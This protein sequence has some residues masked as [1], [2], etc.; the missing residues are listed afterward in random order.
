MRIRTNKKHIWIVPFLGLLLSACGGGGDSGGGGTTPTPTPTPTNQAPTISGSP[1]TS[2]TI[3]SSYTFTPQASDADGDSLSF[4][5]VNAPSWATFDSATGQ[6]SGTPSSSDI[7]DYTNIQISVSDGTTSSSLSAFSIAVQDT[8]TVNTAP[9]ISGVP[10][11][12]ATVDAQYSFSPQA[13]DADGDTLTFSVSNLPIWAS[14]N[15][16]NGQISGIPQTSNVG[17]Y[18]N[19]EIIVSDGEEGASLSP[20][21]ITVV[22]NVSLV[23][24]DNDGLSDSEEITIGTHPNVADTDGDGFLDKEEV[25]NWDQFS[26]THL[27]FNPLVADVPRLRMERLGAPVIQLYATTTESGS[28]SKGMSEEN[29]DEVQTITERGR[30]NTNVIEEEHA[31]NVNGE[32]ETN[33]A[34]TT[35]R[36]EAS[37]DYNHTDTN[38]E[39]NYWN[40]TTVETNR[41]AS[42][43][44][45][46]TINSETVQTSGGEI[47]VL[48]G[49]LNDGDVSYT[50]NNM[51]ISAFME[52]PESPGDLIAVGTLL[53]DGD[54]TFT[55]PP[56]GSAV[57]PSDND[58]TAFN[59]VYRAE[60]NPEEISRILENS[61]RLVFQA[62]NVSLTGQRADVDLNLAAQNVRART[63]EVIIDYGDNF[64]VPTE[65]YRVAIDDGANETLSFDDLMRKRLNYTYTFS[66]EAFTGVTE[67]N[68][69]LS[70]LRG[71][72]MNSATNSYWLLAHTFT[73]VGAPTGT[74][75][76]IM[77]NILDDDYSA[78]DITLRK[79][80]VLHFVYITDSDLDG[81]SDRLEV[82]EG[83]DIDMADTDQD[84]L[85]DALETYGFLSNLTAA[86]C[87]QGDDLFLVFAN[88][89]EA[90]S[91]SDGI[92]DGDEFNSC[93]N[94]LGDLAVQA[95]ADELVDVNQAISLSAEPSNFRDRSNLTYSWT[96]TGG[97]SVG[98]L[99][100]TASVS[101]DA[102]SD[103]TNL[104]FIVSV[105]D[106]TL[107]NST[108]SDSV[109]V[110][111]AQDKTRAVFVDADNGHDF[112]NTGRSP[113]LALRTIARAL[114]ED[115]NGN[116][117]YLNTPDSGFYELDETFELPASSS[118]FGGFDTQWTHQPESNPT[119]IKV[120]SLVAIRVADFTSTTISG[121]RIEASVTESEGH[122]K[123]LEVLNGTTLRLDKV[124]TKAAD[125]PAEHQASGIAASSYGVFID[126]VQRVDIQASN[127]YAGNGAAGSQGA[128]GDDG[129]TGD[130]GSNG[131]A[132]RDGGSGG[133][134]HN[135]GNGGSGGTAGG[136]VVT[137]R[138]GN[139][140][141]NGTTNGGVSG[142]SAGEGANATLSIIGICSVSR[143]G[144]TGSSVTSRAST[145][146]QGTSATNSTN[147][148]NGVFIPS[149][150]A[151]S[152]GQ[153]SGGAGGGGGGSGAGVDLNFG[154]GGGG[155]GEGG[156][157]GEGGQPGK[158]AGGSFGILLHAVDFANI[159]NSTI[160]SASGG[161]GGAGGSGGIGGNGGSG[162][163]GGDSG[164]REGGDGGRGG[165]G[166]FGGDG[167]GGAGGPV[168]AILLF[169]GTE[170]D[171][172]DSTIVTGSG[173]NG[174][175]PNRGQGGWN[176]GIFSADSN[177]SGNVN[178]TF[179]I[180]GAGNDADSGETN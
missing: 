159:E 77:Y 132:S 53:F 48:M 39:V 112:N 89:L 61:N 171:I 60:N 177:L 78:A 10:S 114:S 11:S 99:P 174:T 35:A 74:T 163:S 29:E 146:S 49:L 110:F 127:L 45:Y 1:G 101:F 18:Q 84:G 153:G 180:G 19:I 52:N 142:G 17:L 130:A 34:V 125:L 14:F 172:T 170:L 138:D 41:Q 42:S 161:L 91:D 141:S 109:S 63:A 175:T 59:F 47:K 27:R 85:D 46:E 55:P 44:Y 6:L 100:N 7:G 30:E 149:N 178:N 157:G 106:T 122:S 93:T 111:V 67:S 31:V 64:D 158:G 162:G 135:G 57:Q 155:G 81:L 75:D 2:V 38:T 95:S 165:P 40:E 133:S 108:A 147:F 144:I 169:A 134:G 173:G 116:D 20:F 102:P 87:N 51:N 176:Y 123:A 70:S 9:V 22:A 151:S 164:A 136:G 13:S 66:A 152:G 33:G 62:A 24:T 160:S 167:G 179:Q 72:A 98:V 82:L 90:D 119:P 71:V 117:I 124:T 104:Q 3:E 16:S 21:S 115:F 76:T 15:S 25:D 128:E 73:P 150:G 54:M 166:G 94:P 97:I 126:S 79:G 148:T 43:E 83:T 118:L 156:E 86:P 28:V 5:I 103:V 37:Y 58:F 143:S 50:L 121:I 4:S 105:S 69:G 140:G 96:Q 131:S 107:E 8:N 113:E 154:G 168:A 137:C 65:R 56:L 139:D 145:G 32:V 80:D 36:A 129:D 26:G 68:T 23:D 88:P 120:S 12:T 92:S